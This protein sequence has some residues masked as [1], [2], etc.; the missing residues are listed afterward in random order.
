MVDKNVCQRVL[1]SSLANMSSKHFTPFYR[2]P[3]HVGGG[4]DARQTVLQQARPRKP[5][6][7]QHEPTPEN[8]SL[9]RISDPQRSHVL[10]RSQPLHK[11][12]TAPS[13]NTD[14]C[15]KLF[16]CSPDTSEPTLPRKVENISGTRKKGAPPQPHIQPW[17]SFG[18][19]F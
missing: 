9:I 5:S 19:A 14:I 2:S 1:P 15:R 18:H 12:N 6:A 3:T 4:K 11:H 13:H 17:Q 7:F 10:N 8:D 16:K